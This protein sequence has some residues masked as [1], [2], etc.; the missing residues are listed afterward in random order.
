MEKGLKKIIIHTGSL[1]IGG[2]EKMLSELLKVINLNKYKILLLIE[3]DCGIKNIYEKDIPNS[4]EY[5]FL[6]TEKFMQ[7]L[8]KYKSS[9]NL[10]H[11]IL[12]SVLLKSK[13][14]IA[15]KN[16]KKNL[17]YSDIIIDYNLGL[18]RHV[19]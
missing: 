16:L 6:T 8:E 5:K 15:I 1:K 17:N 2:Q 3:E 11:K 10:I 12:Y 9:K 7:K 14:K 19:N 18:L 13:K 4:V